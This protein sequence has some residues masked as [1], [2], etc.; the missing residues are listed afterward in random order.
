MDNR[1]LT[2][3]GDEFFP[4]FGMGT[5]HKD[6]QFA[7]D[8]LLE[9]FKQTKPSLVYIMPTKGT[10]AFVAVICSILQIPYIMVSPYPQFFNDVGVMDKVNIKKATESAKSFIMMSDTPAET[11]QDAKDLFED[12]VEFLCRV[13]DAVVFCYSKDTTLKYKSFMEETSS[14]AREKC[15]LELIYDRRQVPVED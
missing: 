15:L 10:C 2:V 13:A 5:S 3:F 11:V 7:V 1:I 6:R 4:K 8:N 14:K 9:F 12:S